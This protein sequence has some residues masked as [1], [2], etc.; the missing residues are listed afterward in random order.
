MTILLIPSN[1]KI[2]KDDIQELEK[3]ITDNFQTISKLKNTVEQ[4]ELDKN[5]LLK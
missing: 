3:I 4:K 2:M 5:D 1:K